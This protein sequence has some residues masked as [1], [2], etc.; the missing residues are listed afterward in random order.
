[1]PGT[2]QTMMVDTASDVPWVQCHPPLTGG[3]RFFDPT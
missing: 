1:M 3:I 2:M